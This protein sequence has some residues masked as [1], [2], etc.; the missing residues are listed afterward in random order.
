ML[1]VRGD[2]Y[3]AARRKQNE[4]LARIEDS[5]SR[6]TLIDALEIGPSDLLDIMGP[7]EVTLAFLD[8][9]KLIASVGLHGVERPTHVRSSHLGADVPLRAPDKLASWLTSHTKGS[10]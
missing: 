9:H 8:G 7:A 4:V 2:G 3:D 10:I 6:S 1:I 5:G